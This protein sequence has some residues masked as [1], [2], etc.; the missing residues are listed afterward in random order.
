MVEISET[1]RINARTISDEIQ[2]ITS[3]FTRQANLATASLRKER[4]E[5]WAAERDFKQ[6]A[7]DF[8]RSLNIGD[9]LHIR[10]QVGPGGTIVNTYDNCILH[11]VSVIGLRVNTFDVTSP[12]MYGGKPWTIGL[13]CLLSIKKYAKDIDEPNEKIGHEL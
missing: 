10:T 9:R 4:D 11:N 1:I 7:S 2:E 13:S 6:E 3:D 5:L 8:I 12:D